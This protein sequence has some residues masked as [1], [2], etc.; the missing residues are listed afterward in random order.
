MAQESALISRVRPFF[1]A[2]T[3]K[4]I[5]YNL[6]VPLAACATREIPL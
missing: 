6:K 3:S 2:R 5:E 4:P 1:L